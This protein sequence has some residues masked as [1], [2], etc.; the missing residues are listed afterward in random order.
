MPPQAAADRRGPASAIKGAAPCSGPPKPL[1]P[2]A[3]PLR[4]GPAA[5]LT[6]TCCRPARRPHCDVSAHVRRRGPPPMTSRERRVVA[7]R[8]R[9]RGCAV[10]FR[11]R[12]SAV[13][14]ELLRASAVV[15]V[16]CSR[17]RAECAGRLRVLDAGRS[18]A[19]EASAHPQP[20]ALTRIHQCPAALFLSASGLSPSTAPAASPFPC[21]TILENKCSSHLPCCNLRSFSHVLSRKRGRP[22]LHCNPGESREQRVRAPLISLCFGPSSG[23]K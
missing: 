13:P 11:P 17:C 21:V 6:L 2:P 18:A 20:R 3:A 8:N 19:A 1:L 5:P 23:Q 15:L 4:P 14:A 10:R 12:G 9:A 22:A 16:A 7:R